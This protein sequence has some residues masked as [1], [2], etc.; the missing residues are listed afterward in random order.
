MTRISSVSVLALAAMAGPGFA[1]IT[2]QQ[3]WD[4]MEAYL[5]GFGYTIDAREEASG[6]VLT[7]RDLTLTMP[8]PEEDGEAVVTIPDM[9]YTAK[10]DGSV[11]ITMPEN[12]MVGIAFGPAGGVPEGKVNL[13]LTHSGLLMNV[14]GSEGDM[15][16]TYS[17]ERMTMALDSI[18]DGVEAL[19]EDIM[20]AT[21]SAGPISG[22]SRVRTQDGLQ[23]VMQ[24]ARY[25]DI[26]YDFAFNNPDDPESKGMF[27]GTLKGL[28]GT[29][30]TSIPEN[31][32]FEDP[33]A[34]FAA[35]MAVDATVTHQ[36]GQTEFNFQDGLDVV[37]GR[38]ASQGGTVRV[39]MSSAGMAYDVSAR[40]QTVSMMVPDVPFPI[41]AQFTEAG[42]SFDLPLA[43]SDTPVPARLS[44]RLGDFTM[45]DMLWNIFDPNQV[46]PRDPATIGA[47]LEAQVTPMVD[48]MDPEAMAAVEDGEVMPGELNSVTLKD[49]IISAVGAKI[50]GAG[51]FTFDNSDFD[52]FDGFPA[53]EGALTLQIAGVNGVI[54]KLIQM[55]LVQEQDAMGARMML[56]MFTVPGA[57]P[58]TASSKIE[59]NGEGH[60]L[61]NGQRIK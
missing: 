2:P 29:G 46:L 32:D 11:D 48:F 14:A 52:T 18:T 60:V 16:Y 1:D 38:M 7:L 47:T 25:G 34:I 53:P 55:G 31:A 61:A 22:T 36:G 19:P 56:G 40:G 45:A 57:D 10:G 8:V 54:D 49:L 51:D 33:A 28:T 37:T 5:T 3:A 9:T 35:G 27:K 17:A 12:G 4:S 15:T 24:D 44:I 58:D 41:E 50:T 6:E 59:V 26:S 39:D 23:S 13:S 43:K 30:T 21:M 42:F 20:R